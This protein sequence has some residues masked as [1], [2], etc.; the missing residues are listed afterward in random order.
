LLTPQKNGSGP[1]TPRRKLVR[2]HPERRRRFKLL[3]HA[4]GLQRAHR[5]AGNGA[6]DDPSQSALSGGT[7]A[8]RTPR[9]RL[10]ANK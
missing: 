7:A 10:C 2:G 5:L 6:L 9:P 1:C 3:A 4:L 8:S